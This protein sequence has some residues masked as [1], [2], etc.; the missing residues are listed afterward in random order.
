MPKIHLITFAD[1]SPEYHA[2]GKRLIKQSLLFPQIDIRKVFSSADLGA[3]YHKIFKPEI[4]T[5]KVGF[6]FYSWKPYITHQ[7]LNQISDGDILV[8]IDCGCEL[9][10]GGVIRF[11]DYLSITCEYGSLLFEHHHPL[12]YWTKRHPQL[13]VHDFGYR[14]TLVATAF[15][16]Q[17]NSATLKFSKN[18]LDLSAI[19]GGDVLSDPDEGEIQQVFFKAHRHDQATFSLAAYENDVHSIADETFFKYWEYAKEYPILAFHN[20]TGSEILSKKLKK[21]N[22]FKRSGF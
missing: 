12:R 16:L 9:N 14:N 21:R 5:A 18:W 11:D 20:R 3:E 7:Y 19:D 13:N 15:F 17:K 6:G 1:G 22:I 4:T 8:Y 2:A 10:P